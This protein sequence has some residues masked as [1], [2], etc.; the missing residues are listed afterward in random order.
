[1]ETDHWSSQA[2]GALHG[3]HSLLFG[4]S[5]KFDRETREADL[6]SLFLIVV[7]PFKF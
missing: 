5:L 2:V 7:K 6:F 4:I 1:M 3:A